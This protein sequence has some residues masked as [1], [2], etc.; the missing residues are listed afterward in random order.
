MVRVFTGLM[1]VIVERSLAAI[2][3][4]KFKDAGSNRPFSGV[5]KAL[6]LSTETQLP[7]DVCEVRDKASPTADT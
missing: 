4:P 7:I 1:K 2:T 6:K 5:E 3:L